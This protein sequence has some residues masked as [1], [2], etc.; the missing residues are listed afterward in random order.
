MF[1]YVSQ[2]RS[3]G[4]K[5]LGET[6]L[7]YGEL[8]NCQYAPDNDGNCKL[9]DKFLSRYAVEQ[10][11]RVETEMLRRASRSVLTLSISFRLGG[12]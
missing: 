6:C 4:L 9:T 5:G 7:W 11:N 2:W 10:R 3:R 8:P 1:S 12:L